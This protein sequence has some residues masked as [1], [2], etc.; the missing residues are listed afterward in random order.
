M[1]RKSY[2]TPDLQVVHIQ[3]SMNLLAGSVGA[4][5]GDGD[6]SL[7][8]GGNGE[9]VSSPRGHDDSWDWD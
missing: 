7:G 1:N 8:G 2:Q 3:Q 6:F 4:V 5:D 9:G